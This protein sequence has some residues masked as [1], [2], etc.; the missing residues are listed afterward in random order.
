MKVREIMSTAVATC[1]PRTSVAEAAVQMLHHDCGVLPVVNDMGEVLGMITDRDIAI[2]VATRPEHA[3][4]IPVATVSSGHLLAVDPDDDVTHALWAMQQGQVHRLPVVSR[5]GE[6]V[7]ILSM[8]DLI[9]RSEPATRNGSKAKLTNDTVINALKEI[10]QHLPQTEMAM[11]GAALR[12]MP[13]L[14]LVE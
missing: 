2:A 10:G 4:E 12:S 8:N 5:K 13:A 9:L 6:L 11:N 14:E 1:S 7:G 3:S